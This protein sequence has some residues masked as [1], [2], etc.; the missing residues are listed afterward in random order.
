[1]TE[2]EK[3][4]LKNEKNTVINYLKEKEENAEKEM[5]FIG[6]QNR[7][8]YL[9]GYADAMSD[10]IGIL[11]KFFNVKMNNNKNLNK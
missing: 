1:M 3:R 8:D 2:I 9:E 10:A 6:S 11:S 4:K 5:Q 7:Y